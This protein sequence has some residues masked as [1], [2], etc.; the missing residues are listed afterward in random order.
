MERTEFDMSDEEMVRSMYLPQV[1]I[2]MVISIAEER[3][4]KLVLSVGDLRELADFL[5]DNEQIGN[6]IY[7]GIQEALDEFLMEHEEKGVQ[8]I[9]KRFAEGNLL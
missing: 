5:T 3:Y 4:P 1:T 2:D 9:K 8:V 7:Y 6:G